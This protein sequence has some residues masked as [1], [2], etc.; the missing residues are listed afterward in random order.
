MDK[1]KP[2]ILAVET[3]TKV[4]SLA[5]VAPGR[6][7]GQVFLKS[8]LTHDAAL[9]GALQQLLKKCRKK[10]DDVDLM[11]VSQGP[12]SFTG[13]RV[14]ISF[15]RAIAQARD[16]QVIP[17]STLDALAS[18]IKHSR[19]VP[20]CALLDA[21]KGEVWACFYREKGKSLQRKGK[22]F[23]ATPSEL[24]L[25]IK[26]KTILLGEGWEKY[27][28][29]LKEILGKKAVEDYPLSQKGRADAS[30]V[31]V[32]AHELMKKKKAG[33]LLEVLPL[34]IRKPIIG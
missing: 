30:S 4:G 8:S 2:L 12:G 11:A 33:N 6:V 1:A 9:L 28:D 24:A 17:V 5:L 19:G 10:I 32:L 7:V 27:R 20:V 23:N 25:K 22:P 3:A 31:G 21:N 14:G 26:E 13:L 34:Y 29:A 15:A 18:Q 16:I